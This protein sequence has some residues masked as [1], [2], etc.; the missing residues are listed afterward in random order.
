[1]TRKP[2]L[3]AEQAEQALFPSAIA[4]TSADTI[5]AYEWHTSRLG[6]AGYDAALAALHARSLATDPAFAALLRSPEALA[7]VEAAAMRY[8]HPSSERE[9]MSDAQRRAGREAVARY[10]R[11]IA[12]QLAETPGDLQHP[13]RVLLDHF[14]AEDRAAAE[15][16]ADVERAR[17]EREQAEQ[18]REAAKRA[19]LVKLADVA[20]AAQAEVDALADAHLVAHRGARLAHRRA[21][22]ARLRASGLVDLR[23][24]RSLYAV[25]DL[26]GGGDP[27]L[28]WEPGFLA[29]IQRVLDEHDARAV[30]RADGELFELEASL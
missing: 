27:G 4:P 20:R 12:T 15:R 29:A 25:Q 23:I 7:D 21:L 18:A 19:E 9:S 24:G 1:M 11:T 2:D 14:A 10:R 17:A 5:R 30:D 26:L 6:A 22:A 13:A 8:A 3:T 16:V 28:D